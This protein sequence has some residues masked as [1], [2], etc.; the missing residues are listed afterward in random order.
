MPARPGR[1][2][3]KRKLEITPEF[4]QTDQMGVVHN[5]VY[6]LW[7]ERGRFQVLQEVLPFDEALSLGMAMPVVENHCRYK[8]PVRFGDPLVL[9]TTHDILSCYEGRL[10]FR[11]SLVHAK[12]KIEMASGHSVSTLMKMPSLQL[13]K[14]WPADCWQRYSNLQ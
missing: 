5:S 4:Y 12:H 1:R 9:I 8:K 2:T 7:F 3:I 11:H 14:E 10:M 6:F 13:V